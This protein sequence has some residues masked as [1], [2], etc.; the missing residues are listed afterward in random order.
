MNI[1]I[2]LLF[3]PVGTYKVCFSLVDLVLTLREKTNSQILVTLVTLVIFTV[4]QFTAILLI[5]IA[6][7]FGQFKEKLH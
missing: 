2:L 1:I 4:S 5:Y 3:F 7:S 6:M